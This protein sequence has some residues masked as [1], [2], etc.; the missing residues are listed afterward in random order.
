MNSA[1]T[2]L[3]RPSSSSAGSRH[4]PVATADQGPAALAHADAPVRGPDRGCAVVGGGLAVQG[5]KVTLSREGFRMMV[6]RGFRI[7]VIR[8]KM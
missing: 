8:G 6:I 3:T 2:K 4:R 7:L 1:P 5:A